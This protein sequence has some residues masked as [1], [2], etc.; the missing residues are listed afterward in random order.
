MS[1]LESIKENTESTCSGSELEVAGPI[2]LSPEKALEEFDSVDLEKEKVITLSAEAKNLYESGNLDAAYDIYWQILQMHVFDK[3]ILFDVYK[4]LGNIFLKDGDFEEAE[5]LFNKACTINPK[6]DALLVNYGVLETQRHNL[7]RARERFREAIDLNKSNDSA[8][9][10]L[11]LVHREYGDNDLSWANLERAL[12]ENIA[13][14]TAL[15]IAMDWGIKDHKLDR[16]A[17]RTSEYLRRVEDNL[18]IRLSLAKIFFC[19]GNYLQALREAKFVREIN[20]EN[21]DAMRLIAVIE[22]EVMGGQKNA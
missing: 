20:P 19:S 6:S 1:G 15:A 5:E 10:G 17:F 3:S 22:N 18:E 12:D 13:N 16:V 14:R 2:F 21:T 9:V 8:W 11:A 4:N 7:D